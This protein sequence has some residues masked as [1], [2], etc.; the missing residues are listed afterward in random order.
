MTQHLCD[1]CSKVISSNY[2]IT[3]YSEK[4]QRN[5]TVRVQNKSELYRYSKPIEICKECPTHEIINL[6]NPG[7]V[8]FYIKKNKL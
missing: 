2:K 7:E 5:I 4:L 8:I 3:G 1:I 6:K